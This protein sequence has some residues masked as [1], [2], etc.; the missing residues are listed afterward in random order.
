MKNELR[1]FP[2]GV[3]EQLNSYVYLYKDPSTEQVFYIGKGQGD[4][5]FSHLTEADDPNRE[6]AKV[7]RI[8][9]IWRDELEVIVQIHRHS[10]TPEE[11]LHVEASLIEIFPDATN[12][13]EGHH[14]SIIGARLVSD[15]INEKQR[16]KAIFDFP[17]VLINIRK[18]WLKIRP[19]ASHPVDAAQ[20]YQSTRTAWSMQPDRHKNVKHAAAVAFGIVRELY[21]IDGWLP[22][23]VD[24]D[25]SLRDPEDGRWMF[26]GRVVHDKS[27]I[28]G[29]AIDHLQKPGSQNPIRWL[30]NGSNNE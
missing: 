15:L 3:A 9:R 22:A 4:R 11:A 30:D 7:E 18:E 17:I 19:R 16:E 14:S 20:L 10:M 1:A 12:E 26:T 2:V 8:R 21:E 27:G 29:K 25:G 5:V 13:V 23:D 6:S 28:V 24:A